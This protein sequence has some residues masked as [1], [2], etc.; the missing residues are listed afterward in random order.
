[1]SDF[2]RLKETLAKL[3]ERERIG[4]ER[5]RLAGSSADA[6]LASLVIEIDETI[7]P[8]RLSFAV[9]DG[10]TL[11]L[12]V[13][14]R[15]LQA[16]VSPA[17]DIV[18]QDT[19]EL[20]DR[21]ITDVEDDAVAVLKDLV[22]AV[23]ADAKPVTIQSARMPGSL[24]ASDVGVPANIL[25]RAWGISDVPTEE[26]SPEDVMSRFLDDLG[27]DAVAWLRI[28]GEDIT[29]QGGEAADAEALGEHAAVFLDGYF[30]KF[31]TLYP[32]IG[33]A[34]GTLIGPVGDMGNAAFFAE[35][36]ELSAFV[37]A[38]PDRALAVVGKWQRL[39]AA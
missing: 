8:R 36:G 23:F 4:G 35:I 3:S 16:M 9:E 10:A 26:L 39:A 21:P 38:R 33:G 14:N 29:D 24:F 30:S 12:A 2:D 27:D 11:H 13:A 7:L 17:P 37:A 6:L 19:G 28:E 1:M 32:D 31:E 18:G 5:R 20:A 22:L 34:C 15:R 25:A